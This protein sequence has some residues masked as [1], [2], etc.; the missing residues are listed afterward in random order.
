MIKEMKENF[1]KITEKQEKALLE[2]WGEYI[3][4][5]FTEQDICEQ[6]RKVMNENA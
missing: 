2:Y 4:N 5:E 6:T 3:E 1:V